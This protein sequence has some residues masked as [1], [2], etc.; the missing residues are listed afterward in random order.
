M[1]YLH[2]VALTNFYIEIYRSILTP[3]KMKTDLWFLFSVHSLTMLYMYRKFREHIFNGFTVK[4]TC[5][6]Y[7][8][9]LRGSNYA[10]VKRSNDFCFRTLPDDK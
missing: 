5:I 8:K 1:F 10:N 4:E 3:F 7:E 2:R 6:P 9:I